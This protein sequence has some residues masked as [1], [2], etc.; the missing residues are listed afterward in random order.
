VSSVLLQRLLRQND[1]LNQQSNPAPNPT[2]E[3]NNQ[4]PPDLERL[5]ISQ[6]NVALAKWLLG[7]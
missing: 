1:S 7:D 5:Q 3:E 4:S 6:N 2:S